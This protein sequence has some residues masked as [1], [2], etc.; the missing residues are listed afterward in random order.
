MIARIRLLPFLLLLFCGSLT[1]GGPVYG[2]VSIVGNEAHILKRMLDSVSP[3]ISYAC[4]CDNSPV[5][6][7]ESVSDT[8]KVAEEWLSG[9]PGVKGE[10]HKDEW[11]NFAYNRNH[12]LLRA[13]RQLAIAGHAQD[14]F[15]LLMDADFELVIVNLTQFMTE[16]PPAVLNMITYEGLKKAAPTNKLFSFTS[17]F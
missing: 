17:F 3:I 14:G 5:P 16:R 12:C 13:R 8:Y 7:A 15:L 10:I 6:S 2:V 1:L 4:I 11:T 9:H